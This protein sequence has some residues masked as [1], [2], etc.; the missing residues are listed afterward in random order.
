M[1]NADKSL[2]SYPYAIWLKRMVALML[3]CMA[4]HFDA[5]AI[6]GDVNGDNVITITDATTI[7]NIVLTG[8]QAMPPKARESLT[9]MVALTAKGSHCSLHL[10]S[11]EPYHA[12]QLEVVL[13]EGGSMGN[14]MLAQGRANGHHAE[15]NEVMPG[16]YN[17]IVYSFNGAA[18]R[19][20][21]STALL[22]FDIANCKADDVSVEASRWLT[23][24]ARR[25]CC[26]PQAA[27]PPASPG[28]W[29]TLPK[30]PAHHTTTPWA[31]APTP[32]SAALTSRTAARW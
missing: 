11:S 31:S 13:P 5:A 25:C 16:R 15:W 1:R 22:H 4:F 27:L 8:V 23:A 9:D 26:H 24:G 14:V 6:N 28:W 10:D 17:V 29:T 18:L 32:S 7:V 12:F 21:S 20:G 3:C 30:A 2:Q 19:N